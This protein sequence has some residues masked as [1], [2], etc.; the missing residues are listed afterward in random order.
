[1]NLRDLEYLV[2][3]EEECHFHRAA[4]RCFV[5][6]PTLSGQLKKLEQEL[7]ILL[8]DRNNRQVVMTEAGQVIA[9]QAR[10]VLLEARAIKEIASTF[11]DPMAGELHVGLIPTVAPYLLPVIMPVLKKSYPKLKLWLHEQQTA[12]LLK[13]L[14]KAELD[15][16]ILALPVETNE[17]SEIDLFN[18][19]FVLAVPKDEQ[20]AKKKTIRLS[21]L[22]NRE[23]LLLEEGHCLRGQALD[24]CF[25]AGA[26]EQSGFQA[27]SLETLR[28]M[29]AEGMG[30]TLL[31]ELSVPKKVR[32]DDTIRYLPFTN[33]QPSRR[34]GMLYRKGSYREETFFNMAGVIKGIIG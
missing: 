17:F 30:M 31:P 19:S 22:D 23:M 12:V 9:E 26:S 7:D 24:V 21:D 25:A 16:L 5:S 1:M 6:Q 8:V 13:Q 3:V 32:K 11:H 20:L 27:T 34:I 2:A 33:P 14:R 29:V 4:E 15:L 18:E 28:H 10:K